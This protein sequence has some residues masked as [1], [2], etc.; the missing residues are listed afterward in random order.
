MKSKIYYYLSLSLSLFILCSCTDSKS[1]KRVSSVSMGILTHNIIDLGEI[2]IGYGGR[3]VVYKDT[4]IGMEAP[5]SSMPPFFCLKPNEELPSFYYFG[6]KGQGPNDF[7]QPYSIQHIEN[8]IIGTWDINARMYYEFAL[9]DEKKEV[10]IDKRVRFEVILL[11]RV[12]KTAYNQFIALMMADDEAMFLLADSTG[13]TVNTFFEYPYRNNDERQRFNNRA[14]FS[15][16]QGELA[17]N[18]S[19]T[20]FVYASDKGEIIHFY[21]IENNNIKPIVKIE[22]EY[23][24]YEN[25][26]IPGGGTGVQLGTEGMRGY[27]S[28]YATEQFVYALFSGKK[29][30]ETNSRAAH[31]LRIFDWN[32]NNVKEYELDVPSLYLCVSDDDSK[33]WAIATNPDPELVYFNLK[34]PNN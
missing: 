7:L 1:K 24:L 23:A 4:I 11:S 10:S 26:E 16:Y 2:F 5:N 25:R 6:N 17:T 20:K 30:G 3:L 22:K 9:P 19:K 18:P 29:V 33:L 21:D 13:K 8:N 27:V 15:A 14:R 32:G 34:N 28:I 12:I 31:T